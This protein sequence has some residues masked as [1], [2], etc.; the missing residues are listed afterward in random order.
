MKTAARKDKKSLVLDDFLGKV[1]QARKSFEMRD[2]PLD[3]P[4]LERNRATKRAL[5]D[6]VEAGAKH[7][8]S[9]WTNGSDLL[10]SFGDKLYADSIKQ[11]EFSRRRIAPDFMRPVLRTTFQLG[12]DTAV[13]MPP[14]DPPQPV[15]D[16]KALSSALVKLGEKFSAAS[17]N[18][19]VRERMNSLQN[20]GVMMQSLEDLAQAM[21]AMAGNLDAAAAI[22]FKRVRLGSPNPQVRFAMYLANW[23]TECAGRPHLPS[24]SRLFEAGFA[25]RKRP[26]PLWIGRLEIEMNRQLRQ[27]FESAKLFTRTEN[28]AG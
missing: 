25:A 7:C 15:F 23:V 5:E 8:A 16:L 27:R 1:Q 24:L 20:S 26:A 21:A 2:A 19:D 14:K 6:L 10:D 17:R 22:K 9:I 12:V 4:A 28:S 3:W 11:D 13:R 18:E